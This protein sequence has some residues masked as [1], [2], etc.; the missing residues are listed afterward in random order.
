MSNA[1]NIT[2]FASNALLLSLL[3][4]PHPTLRLAPSTTAQARE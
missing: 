3:P 1:V 2:L 4:I